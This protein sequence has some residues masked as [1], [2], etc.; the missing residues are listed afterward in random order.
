MAAL[1]PV[2]L[3]RSVAAGS[4]A[5]GAVGTVPLIIQGAISVLA[6]LCERRCGGR[7]DVSGRAGQLIGWG[8]CTCTELQ[9]QQLG[10]RFTTY[11]LD[12][13]EIFSL[14]GHK[15]YLRW[16]ISFRYSTLVAK[17]LHNPRNAP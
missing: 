16:H 7:V 6:W 9:A 4:T 14:A 13:E 2:Q 1:L 11:I 17:T 10:M 5:P 3:C 12:Q 8:M 15:C